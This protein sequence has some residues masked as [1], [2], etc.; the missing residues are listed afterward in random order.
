MLRLSIRS[1]MNL[2][3]ERLDATILGSHAFLS[4]EVDRV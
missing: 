4:F 1:S 3:T 2:S